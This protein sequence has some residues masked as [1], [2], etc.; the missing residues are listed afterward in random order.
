MMMASAAAP[1]AISAIDMALA[2]AA[3]RDRRLDSGPGAAGS[4]EYAGHAQ[5]AIVSDRLV[6]REWDTAA[7][8]S[9]HRRQHALGRTPDTLRAALRLRL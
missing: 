9:S 7:P 5:R 1:N 3:N 4:G 8:A 2:P 6:E